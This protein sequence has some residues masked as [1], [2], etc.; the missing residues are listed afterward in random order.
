MSRKISF[1]LFIIVSVLAQF[2]AI[3]AQGPTQ[4][5]IGCS[6]VTRPSWS[7]DGKH[8]AIEVI[9]DDRSDFLYMVDSNG[10]NPFLLLP[11]PRG[12]ISEYHW[13]PKSTSL[14]VEV[15]PAHLM[16]VEFSKGLPIAEY[17]HFLAWYPDGSKVAYLSDTD[18]KVHLATVLG[19]PSDQA[20]PVDNVDTLSF[21]PE[22]KKIVFSVRMGFQWNL[23]IAD[24]N[25]GNVTEL[26]NSLDIHQTYPAWSPDGS[27]I[28]FQSWGNGKNTLEMVSVGSGVLQ[29]IAENLYENEFVWSPD[30]SQIAFVAEKTVDLAEVFVYNLLNA[31]VTNVSKTGWSQSP[32]WSP[33]GKQIAFATSRDAGINSVYL[34]NSDGTNLHKFLTCAPK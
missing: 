26:T 4:A 6:G 22:G 24:S 15:P 30:G 16:I 28:A 7:P 2:G 9:K 23:F 10:N 19:S 25:G 29:I 31:T 1:V 12:G 18:S 34:V 14:A 3:Q 11:P 21:S 32:T 33:D 27:Q 13:S 20:L 8:I 5:L 17:A